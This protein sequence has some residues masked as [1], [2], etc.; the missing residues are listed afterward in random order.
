MLRK[1]SRSMPFP[2]APRVIYQNNPLIQVICQVRFPPI[3]RIDTETPVDFQ[4]CVRKQLPGYELTYDEDMDS[5]PQSISQSLPPEMRQLLHLG[6]NRRYQFFSKD[7]TWTVSLAKDFVAVETNQ[8][9]KWEDFRERLKLVINTL[10]QVYEPAYLTR[11]GLRYKN[12]IDRRRLHLEGVEW[13]DLLA[14]FVLGQFSRDETSNLVVEQ[15]GRTLVKLNEDGDL[16]RM[17]YGQVIDSAGD[18]SNKM[19]LLDHDFY[20]DKETAADVRDI[21]SRLNTYN[22]LNGRLFRWGITQRLHDAM[23]PI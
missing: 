18:P 17:E 3:L 21:V 9:S 7:R 6:S 19:Y 16:V 11:I 20:I 4:E 14:D 13:R 10:F 5:L 8:Y 2:E 23:G 12:V 15:H 22:S 1:E